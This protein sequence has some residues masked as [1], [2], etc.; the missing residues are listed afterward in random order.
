LAAMGLAH[1]WA[2][3][4]CAG[5]GNCR[6]KKLSTNRAVAIRKGDKQEGVSISAITFSLFSY[7][8]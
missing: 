3:R 1:D 8:R 4:A 2:G 7:F 5:L 6:S